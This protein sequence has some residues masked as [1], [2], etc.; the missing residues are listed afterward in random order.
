MIKVGG[1]GSGASL[2]AIG[3]AIGGFVVAATIYGTASLMEAVARIEINTRAKR[4]PDPDLDE[5]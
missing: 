2:I 3:Q 4:E 1:K 5:I